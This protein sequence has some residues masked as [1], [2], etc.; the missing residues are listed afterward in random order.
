MSLNFFHRKEEMKIETNG[1]PMTE[2]SFDRRSGVPQGYMP[3]GTALASQLQRIYAITC[4][5][6]RGCKIICSF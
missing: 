2:F 3:V 1:L 6:L 4:P 5:D